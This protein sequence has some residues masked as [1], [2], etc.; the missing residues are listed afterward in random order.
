MGNTC[1]VLEGGGLRGAFT[2]GVLEFLLEK[3]FSFD[4][5]IGVS[6]GACVGASYLSHQKGRNFRV[7]VELPSDKRY[8]GLQHLLTTG[9]YF[10]M[11]FVF[12][13][14]PQKLVP[15]NEIEFYSNPAEFDIVTTAL[16]SGKRVVFSKNEIK[17]LGL[18]NVLIASSSI[19]LLS[20]AAMLDGELFYDG[21][22]S[23]SIPVKYAFEK[24]KK[25]VVVLTRPRGYR[26]P[27]MK[28]KAIMKQTF[29]KHPDFLNTLLK[30]NEEYNQTLEFCNDMEQQ[31]K[32]YILA[33]EPIFQIGRIEKNLGRRIALYEHGCELMKRRFDEMIRFLD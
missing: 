25:I 29:K 30:R 12:E 4:R 28:G 19:P 15:F 3:K 23:D 26:K 6:A 14:I 8:M 10:N 20:Q 32:L 9:S 16:Q 31:Q 7:N 13:E 1:I 27:E 33:P 11:Q 18:D 21:G 17:R 22:V 24:H 5:V 2:S